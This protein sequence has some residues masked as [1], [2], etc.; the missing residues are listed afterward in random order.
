MVITTTDI[1][2][3]QILKQ[4]IGEQEAEALVSFVDAK[5]KEA[6][7][8]NLRVLATKEDVAAVKQELANLR[9]ELKADIAN[10]KADTFKWFIGAFM[11]LALMILGL[12]F[13]K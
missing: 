7:D 9:G 8:E 3:F 10:A 2:L 6:N 12:Y 1:Q 11:A 5:I 13:K 4:K